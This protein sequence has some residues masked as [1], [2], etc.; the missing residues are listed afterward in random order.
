MTAARAVRT[1]ARKGP[2]GSL[3]PLDSYLQV[4]RATPVER[5]KMI[6]DGV[7]ATAAKR[8]LSDLAFGQAAAFH[9]LKLSAATVNRKAAEGK[10]LSPDESER[11]L[12]MAKLIG[13]LQSMIQES[14]TPSD[15]DATAWLSRWLQEPV[16]ALG[17]V[18]PVDLMDTM[19]GQTL[20]A[21]TLE[22]VQSGA[23]A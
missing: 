23:Y 2:V 3:P 12:G 9:A 16:P 19:E 4:F 15:F 7:Q 14:A 20:V 17:G 6:K 8:I 5:I 18:R 10:T 1:T 22:K 21:N 11:V 13:Q